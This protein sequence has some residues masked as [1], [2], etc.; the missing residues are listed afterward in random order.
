MYNLGLSGDPDTLN[1]VE[2]EFN[3]IQNG[4]VNVDNQMKANIL[5]IIGYEG[6]DRKNYSFSQL[7]SK[8][9]LEFSKKFQ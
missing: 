3:S 4:I 6:R 9:F 1:F 5:Y 2:K 8:K 7:C